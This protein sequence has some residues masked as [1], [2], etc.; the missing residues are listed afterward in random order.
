MIGWLWCVLAFVA[1]WAV[2]A[3]IAW[4]ESAVVDEN[5]RQVLAHAKGAREQKQ[6]PP[7]SYAPPT[8]ADRAKLNIRMSTLPRD[9]SG[10]ES[11][12]YAIIVGLLVSGLVVIVFALGPLLMRA[13]TQ[14]QAE[15][16][17]QP[18][19]VVEEGR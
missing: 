3:R 17:G 4:S 18:A 15:L 2:R 11:V 1:G 9:D 19:V 7:A 14:A 6:W 8:E 12:E 13:Y 10:L 16:T 5:I